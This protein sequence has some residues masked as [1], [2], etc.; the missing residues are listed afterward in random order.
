MAMLQ[1]VVERSFDW[2]LAATVAAGLVGAVIGSGATLAGQWFLNARQL[3]RHRVGVVKAILGELRANAS[4]ILASLGYGGRDPS[5]TTA[6]AWHRSNHDLAQFVPEKTY[7]SLSMVYAIL[8]V[9]S[10]LL[11][12]ETFK[13]QVKSDPG[14]SDLRKWVDSVVE[15][16][17]QLLEL[18]HA[19]HFKEEWR[20]LPNIRAGFDR[21][22][23]R[24][25]G[26]KP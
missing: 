10:K 17:E 23:E 6:E 9:A 16:E 8:P 12:P 4:V 14:L 20:K 21:E 3:Y 22:M 19:A 7:I 5:E 26:T 2:N 1:V 11:D 15:V 24:I 18:V 13:H 25:R